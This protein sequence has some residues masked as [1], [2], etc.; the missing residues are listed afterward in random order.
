[1]H[2]EEVN[3][4]DGRNTFCRDTRASMKKWGN[5]TEPV[6]RNNTGWAGKR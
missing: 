6:K 2:R 4:L 1:M 5:R 3:V